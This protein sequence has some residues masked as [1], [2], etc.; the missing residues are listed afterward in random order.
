MTHKTTP[1]L[2]AV[3]A[4]SL[5]AAPSASA[6]IGGSGSI[7]GT[8][9]D[10]SGGVVP[11][12]TVTAVNLATGVETA[13]VTTGA[14]VY[15]VS[16]LP[17]GTYRVEIRL[18]GFQPYVREPVIVDALAVVGLNVTLQLSGISQE[19][20]VS[21]GSPALRTADAGLGQTIRNEVYTALPL[22]MNTGGPRDPTAFMFLM[23]G[24]Q[25]VGRWGNVMGGQDFAN[26]T[27]IEGVPITNAVVQGEGRN[28]PMAS[29]WK[30]S[31]SSRSKP[32]ARRSCS[33]ARARRTTSSNPER[34]RFVATRSSSSGTRRST[35]R[36]LCRR[37]A[38]RQS[39]RVRGDAR[40]T[41]PEKRHV[42][43]RR[44]RR[45]PR[46]A[47]D[48]VAAPV[49]SDAGDAKRGL[50]RAAGADLR[51]GDDEAKPEWDR[52]RPRSVSRQ[53]HSFESHLVHLAQFA[54]GSAGADGRR[55]PEQLPRRIAAHRVQQRQRHSKV[56]INVS[57][58]HRLSVLFA[59]GSR[60]QHTP[61]RGGTNAQTALPLPYTETRLVE[62]TPTTAQV[63]HTY[64]INPRWL[65]QLSVGFSRLG[66]P[67]ANATIDGG[68]PTQAGLRGLPPGEADS[69][70]PE[71]SFAGPNAPTQWR[72]TDAR[73]FTEFLNNYTIQNNLQS[74]LGRHA[75]TFGFQGQRLEAEERERT[76]GSL[77]TF[78]FSN[79]Q[80]AGFGPTGTLL[81]TTG[82]AYASYL[83]GE[84]NATTVIEDSQV[85]TTGRFQS[86]AFWVQDDFKAT[87]RLS[88]N[89]GLRYDIMTPY[90]SATTDGRS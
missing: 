16:P 86:Y 73:A 22:V 55:P 89:L 49:G 32:A 18:D 75:I 28:L 87:P 34:I 3:L 11:G 26:D 21:A 9:L 72:G 59:H 7:Q 80:T 60:R 8:I 66:V 53:H 1:V 37:Q 23:P 70:F 67:I 44:V 30:R 76:Y 24:V 25:S 51:P 36:L 48:G 65:N 63:K 74:T 17:P 64:V 45:L 13:R 2:C 41:D 39:A 4:A 88:L 52:V 47:A 40:R 58:A 31:S 33:T 54:V 78:G 42:L 81:T 12:A 20:I 61:Y 79:V 50:Q 68:Y 62:E 10:N 84:L 43:L 90:T 69:A 5:L 82:N 14:G 57:Q 56:D 27:Y 71:T 85:A 29:R 6:Q 15:A 77:A 38:R 46:S 83:L 19:I 35:Q